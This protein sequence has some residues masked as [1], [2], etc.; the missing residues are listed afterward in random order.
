MPIWEQNNL[1]DIIINN[2]KDRLKDDFDWIEDM[3]HAESI[4]N[5]AL[6]KVNTKDLEEAINSLWKYY[7]AAT[8]KF[9]T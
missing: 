6:K 7:N 8:S 5:Q 1:L 4:M 2:D 3:K 9:P